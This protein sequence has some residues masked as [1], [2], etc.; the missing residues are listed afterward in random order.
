M[1][2]LIN[3]KW[4][5]LNLLSRAR[6]ALMPEVELSVLWKGKLSPSSLCVELDEE[7]TCRELVDQLTDPDEGWGRKGAWHLVERWNGCGESARV[8]VQ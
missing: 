8:P 5:G 2:G 6:P 1:R 4:V 3:E 7:V